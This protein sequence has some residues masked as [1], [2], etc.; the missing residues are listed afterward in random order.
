MS[1]DHVAPA[2]S[3]RPA[4]R[5]RSTLDMTDELQIEVGDP[6]THALQLRMASVRDLPKPAAEREVRGVD[7]VDQCRA[8]DRV[9]RRNEKRRVALQLLQ[10]KGPMQA[11]D[12]RLD[13]VADDGQPW[14]GLASGEV[15]CSRRDRR[16]AKPP[17]QHAFLAHLRPSPPRRRPA[18]RAP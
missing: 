1:D 9:R 16:A 12:D 18:H 17:L 4:I 10:A 15:Q 6:D 5:C 3:S 13:E 11:A 14:A 8:I 7:R 2:S